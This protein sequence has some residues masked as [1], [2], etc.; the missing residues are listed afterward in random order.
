MS[1]Q[2]LCKGAALALTAWVCVGCTNPSVTTPSRNLDRPSDV[3]LYCVELEVPTCRPE[4][5]IANVPKPEED[6]EGYLNAYCDQS[7]IDFAT[8]NSPRVNVLPL[9]ECDQEHRALRDHYYLDK[10]YRAAQLLGRD[11]YHPCCQPGDL[12]CTTPAPVCSR[13]TIE[14]LI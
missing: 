6:P 14:A 8:W 9:D 3:A 12:S 4:E 7:T 2:S 13:R 1:A 5:H 10:V 11:P